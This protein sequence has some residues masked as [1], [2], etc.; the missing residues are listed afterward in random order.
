MTNKDVLKILLCSY[1]YD[2]NIKIETYRGD[3]GRIGYDVYA[4]NKDDG[5]YEEVAC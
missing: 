1:G 4:E 5:R 2:R 3:L